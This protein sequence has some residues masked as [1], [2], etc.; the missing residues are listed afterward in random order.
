MDQISIA[1]FGVEAG[2]QNLFPLSTCIFLSFFKECYRWISVRMNGIFGN[3]RMNRSEDH[4]IKWFSPCEL[5]VFP[6]SSTA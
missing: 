3:T 2:I 4:A 1:A 6:R 5:S